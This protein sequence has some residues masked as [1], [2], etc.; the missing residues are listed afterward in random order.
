MKKLRLAIIYIITS[1]ASVAHSDGEEQQTKAVSAIRSFE[2]KKS[3]SEF[4]KFV[5]E[6]SRMA[7]LVPS[8]RLEVAV[9]AL[10]ALDKYIEKNPLPAQT[11]QGNIAPPN[12]GLAGVDPATI[13]DPVDRK[14]YEDEIRDNEKILESYNNFLQAKNIRGIAVVTIK[15]LINNNKDLR[16]V[17]SETCKAKGLSEGS[18]TELNKPFMTQN[19]KEKPRSNK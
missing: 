3:L 2:E 17:L 15:I 6:I 10:V 5:N 16:G 11:P 19:N 4:E 7:D 8:K 12:G 14:K 13:K 18:L 9:E 1:I